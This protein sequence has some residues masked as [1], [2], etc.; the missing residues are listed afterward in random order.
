MKSLLDAGRWPRSLVCA[1]ALALAPTAAT[2]EWSDSLYLSLGGLYLL[3]T[4]SDYAVESEDGGETYTSKE[5]LELES[6]MGFLIAV[7][8]GDDVG[9]RGELEL[10]YRK[11]DWDKFKSDGSDADGDYTTLSFMANGIYAFEASDRMRPYVGVGLGLARH[12]ATNEDEEDGPLFDVDD[13]VF[14]YQGMVGLG[15]PLSEKT[16]ARV[17]YR[18]FATADADYGIDVNQIKGA[19]YGTHSIEAGIRFR[20]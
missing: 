18:Y 11:L 3:P 6:G 15:F 13:T 19:S 12:S 8:A 20:F 4:E 16:E 17:G 14:A 1:L 5:T 9:L 10:G 2:A 7:G